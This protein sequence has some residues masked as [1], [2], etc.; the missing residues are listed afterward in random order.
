MLERVLGNL[1]PSRFQSRFHCITERMGMCAP[2]SFQICSIFACILSLWSSQL[3]EGRQLR[4]QGEL[5]SK[6][7]AALANQG[8]HFTIDVSVGSPAQV[9]SVVIDTGSNNLIIPSCLCQQSKRCSKE[10]RCFTGTNRSSTFSV[11]DGSKGPP[12]MRLAFG[13][14]TIDTVVASDVAAVGGVRAEMSDSLLLMVDKQ[15]NFGGSFEGI[16]GLGL[17]NSK[18]DAGAGDDAAAADDVS[19]MPSGSE[20]MEEALKKALGDI[21]GSMVPGAG[22]GMPDTSSKSKQEMLS[23]PSLKNRWVARISGA[24]SP[25]TRSP[26]VARQANRKAPVRPRRNGS[27]AG[28]AS[29]QVSPK[30]FLNRANISR[31]SMCFNDGA[32]GV[33]RL[34]TP[35][36]EKPLGSIGQVHWGLDF[37]GISVGD[38][39]A[40]VLFCDGKSKTKGQDTACGIIPDSGTTLITGPAKQI[41]TL[42]ES[43]CDNWDRCKSNYTALNDALASAS[44][45]IVKKYGFDPFEINKT[46]KKTEILNLLLSDCAAWKHEDEEFKQMPPLHFHVAGAEGSTTEIEIP[47]ISYIMELDAKKNGDVV[48]ESAQ[49][50]AQKAKKKAASQKMC[51]I[52]FETMEYNT[53]DNGPVWIFGTP[54]FYEYQVGYDLGSSPPSIAFTSVKEKPCG[55][56]S[57][58]AM[59]MAKADEHVRRPRTIQGA[60]RMPFIDTTLP[61]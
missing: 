55:S 28:A 14:G 12:A 18:L 4:H 9:F 61:L 40:P 54:L 52:M 1:E 30:G 58:A 11:Q 45:T 56:C 51:Q 46:V 44:D 17:P 41:D 23:R 2:R 16:L 31:F 48:I 29:M 39:S 37:R 53:K 7:C 38:T 35:P 22:G 19:G 50:A 49:D 5:K 59:L 27:K 47:A 8:T 60:P 25:K 15:L 3:C 13:S 42:L 24:R 10:D 20:D 33:M 21:I 43:I 32:D 26:P 6:G 34:D 57:D 36:S